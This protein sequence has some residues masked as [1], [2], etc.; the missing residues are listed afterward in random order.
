MKCL[1]EVQILDL[2]DGGIAPNERAALDG[3]LA[4]CAPC[5]A[6]RQELEDLVGDL[7][8]LPELDEDAHVKAIMG[9]LDDERP[10]ARTTRRNRIRWGLAAPLASALAIAAGALLFVQTRPSHRED[11]AFT[12]RGG[13]SRHT[14][15][16]DVG[17]SV[18]CGTKT[19]T[20]LTAGAIVEPDAAFTATF[21]NVRDTP[22]YLLLFAIDAKG[23]VHWLYPAYALITGSISRKAFC[24]A[25]LQNRDRC[26]HSTLNTNAL[27]MG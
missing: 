14:L 16:R 20:P 9:R 4:G 22:A 11:P 23:E 7:A 13:G 25:D 17:V 21:T 12:A 2:V 6:A 19:L 3:H 15:A 1:T 5:R 26:M 10:L 27:S 18:R 24:F 8:A